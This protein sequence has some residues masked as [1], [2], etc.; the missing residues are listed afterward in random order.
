VEAC[1]GVRSHAAVFGGSLDLGHPSAESLGSG[2]NRIQ[3]GMRSAS[4][5]RA[6]PERSHDHERF[7]HDPE[8]HLSA[9]PRTLTERDGQFLEME[10]CLVAAVI[11]LDLDGVAV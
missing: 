1:L 10:A 8:T 7:E 4:S 3:R 2:V 9:A 11:Q 6:Q 5:P